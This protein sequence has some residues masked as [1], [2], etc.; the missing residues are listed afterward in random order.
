[1]SLAFLSCEFPWGQEKHFQNQHFETET[2]LF[3]IEYV[4]GQH[5]W[6]QV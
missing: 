2:T 6:E 1:M 4:H 3:S 5:A